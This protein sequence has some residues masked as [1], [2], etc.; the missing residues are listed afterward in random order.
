MIILNSNKENKIEKSHV[1]YDKE[2]KS[3]D[4]IP[5]LNS[6]IILTVSYVNIGFDSETMLANQIWGFSPKEC[7]IEKE[8]SIPMNSKNASLKLETDL[9]PGSWRL[10]RE[11]QWKVYYNSKTLWI[12]IGNPDLDISDEPIA[13]LENAVSVLSPAGELKSLWIQLQS[14]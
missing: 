5:K 7:W 12:C 1:I 8:I 11:M 4:S 3:L 10:D 2:N 13:F 6:D 14:A 9:E